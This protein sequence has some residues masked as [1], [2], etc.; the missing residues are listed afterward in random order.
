MQ[1]LLVVEGEVFSEGW[2][3]VQ[4]ENYRFKVQQD[5]APVARIVLREYLACEIAW[6]KTYNDAGARLDHENSI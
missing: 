4:P 1:G 3:N 5:G 6:T 2:L